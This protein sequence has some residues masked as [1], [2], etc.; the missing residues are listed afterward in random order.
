M[1][2]KGRANNPTFLTRK[3]EHRRIG[4]PMGNDFK[5]CGATLTMDDVKVIHL[6]QIGIQFNDT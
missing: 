4:N 5:G 6:N 2:G 1:S 3:K